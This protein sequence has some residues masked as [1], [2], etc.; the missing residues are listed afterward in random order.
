MYFAISLSKQTLLV[1]E[2]KKKKKEKEKSDLY[3]R[4]IA[5]IPVSMKMAYRQETSKK[6]ILMLFSGILKVTSRIERA[7]II[8][9]T[10][11]FLL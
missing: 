1:R 10:S 4:S 6:V 11:V 8:I 3:F 7:L 9:Q 5:K 2:K